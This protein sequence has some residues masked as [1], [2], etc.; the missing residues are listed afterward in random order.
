MEPPTGKSL[1]DVEVVALAS[2]ESD[3]D[4]EGVLPERYML[5]WRCHRRDVP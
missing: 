4:G 5:W 3:V 1:P 2:P